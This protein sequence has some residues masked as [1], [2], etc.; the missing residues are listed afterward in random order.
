MSANK[1]RILNNA[2]GVLKPYLGKCSAAG[3]QALRKQL[4]QMEFDLAWHSIDGLVFGEPARHWWRAVQFGVLRGRLL[5]LT[6]RLGLHWGATLQRQLL[7]KLRP[8]TS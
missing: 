3:Q 6:A 5:R 4:G 1:C 2:V 8:R 7:R